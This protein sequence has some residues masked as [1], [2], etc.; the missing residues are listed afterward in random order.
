MA[1]V[2]GD[3]LWRSITHCL[4][5]GFALFAAVVGVAVIADIITAHVS[6]SARL[7]HHEPNLIPRY[8][9]LRV[10]FFRAFS[11]TRLFFLAEIA[12]FALNIAAC[13]VYVVGTYQRTV[14]GPVRVSNLVLGSIFAFD[15]LVGLIVAE[16]AVIHVCTLNILFQCLSVPSFF[17]ALGP[18]GF[19]N[20]TFLRALTAYITYRSVDR[21]IF[22][23]LTSS[24]SLLFRLFVKCMALVY[25]LAAGVQLLEIP[26]DILGSSFE[27]TWLP[28]GE[29]HFLTAVYFVVV[30]LSTVGYGDYTP[31]T[32]LGRAFVIL[33]IVIGVIIFS[34]SISQLVE[35]AQRNRGAGSFAKRANSRHVI[36]SGT[37]QLSDLVRFTSEFYASSRISNATAK[38]V[39]VVS[40]PSWTD[41]EWYHGLARNEYL[42]KRVVPLIGNIRSSTDLN[43]ARISS[44]DAI[45]F[46]AS[47]ANGSNSKALDMG[48]VIDILAVR[49]VRT[50]IPIYTTVLLNQSVIQM[51]VAQTLP[52]SP[53]DPNLL[54]RQDMPAIAQYHGLG[55]EIL[56][57]EL[58]SVPSS[59]RINYLRRAYTAGARDLKKFMNIPGLAVMTGGS[60][61]SQ[62]R[63]APQTGASA[64]QLGNER[65]D[66]AVSGD[67]ITGASIAT[68]EHD[69]ARSTSVCLQDI[70]AAVIAAHVSANGVGTL[71]SN[72]VL[73]FNVQSVV[74]DPAW[75]LE[76]HLGAVC[77]L[78]YLVIPQQLDGARIDDI[79]VL[80]YDH[81]LVLVATTHDVSESTSKIVLSTRDKVVKG[82]IGMFL[83]YHERRYAHPALMLAAFKYEAVDG[84]VGEGRA[85]DEEPAVDTEKFPDTLDCSHE[86]SNKDNCDAPLSEEIGSDDATKQ[87]SDRGGRRS[88]KFHAHTRK[89]LPCN[90]AVEA[91]EHTKRNSDTS[92]DN[93]LTEDDEPDT[94]HFFYDL[95]TF[96]HGSSSAN[97]EPHADVAFLDGLRQFAPQRRSDGY[98]PDNLKRHIIISAD[99]ESPLDNLPLLLQYLWRSHGRR[100]RRL[101]RRRRVPIIVIHPN[102][103]DGF[104]AP[105]KRYDGKCLFFIEDSS[106]SRDTWR[107][108]MLK[109]AKGVI[110]LADYGIP[111]QESDARTIFSI[112][113]L[114]TFIEN[115]QDV[116]VVSEL[117]E[118]KSLEFLRE[119]MHAR[120]IGVDFGEF[121]GICASDDR[122]DQT[123]SSHDSQRR[124]REASF[125]DNNMSRD[126]ANSGSCSV[127][128][129]DQ[130]DQARSKLKRAP[131]FLATSK[132]ERYGIIPPTDFASSPDEVLTRS[133]AGHSKRGT[134]FSRNRYASG[135]LLIH[136]SA[137]AL[138]VREYLEPGF[139][140][141]YTELLGA[142]KELGALKIRLVQ[143]PLRMFEAQSLVEVQDGLQ[144][145]R[146]RE[147][148]IRLMQLGATPLGL[149]RSGA[150]PVRIPT[151]RRIHR[152]SEIEAGTLRYLLE[153][154]D[155]F[156]AD[157]T[158]NRK[159]NGFLGGWW[160]DLI[161]V[162]PNVQREQQQSAA[163]RRDEGLDVDVDDDISDENE[164]S[165]AAGHEPP[166]QSAEPASEVLKQSN[167][168]EH[169]TPWTSARLEPKG[170]VP[171]NL[172]QSSMG[173]FRQMPPILRREN[174]AKLPIDTFKEY[175]LPN[176]KL[177]YVLT[178]PEPYTLVSEK[179][180]V[181]ILCHPEFELPST[182]SEGYK[183]AGRDDSYTT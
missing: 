165:G 34:N 49:N 157:D 53:K 95:D 52:A 86:E 68:G 182:W 107:R 171:A 123:G 16:S 20:F 35:N 152:G 42:R 2:S 80:L 71:I 150:A 173:K 124:L 137:L 66:S 72:M 27:N 76:Y 120:R 146:Y 143:V 5:G 63:S 44:A 112:M 159:V 140:H 108:A 132:M 46:I 19:L 106:A 128:N 162:L 84:F 93:Y 97:G 136:S 28:L 153:T 21:R 65:K 133:D 82:E 102:F 176:N 48:T 94:S 13:A 156:C 62:R 43:R 98:I 92:V 70:H 9:Q 79:A 121:A 131:S 69:L 118:E 147:V 148:F 158:E 110:I 1:P 149:Y 45:F 174:T 91:A 129:R 74:G 180:G 11:G 36:V 40:N 85:V 39:V 183:L 77:H 57:Q 61:P 135:D 73:D 30:S 138:L 178:M 99:G 75:L 130:D 10:R 115:D 100:S 105:F 175:Q 83:T 37:P 7:S 24:K 166:R 177:P 117:I 170:Y 17:L 88:R 144:C 15:L 141:F 96:A 89:G 154:T 56:A 29:W 78:T 87:K 8:F 22:A 155:S 32:M 139:V 145:I 127:S 167:A 90:D 60:E 111:W 168:V 6:R 161:N 169:S 67:D 103:P 54:F 31:V 164:I 160:S 142:G 41:T 12:R 109:T 33:M 47:P 113:T 58:Q 59:L 64:Q 114:D 26:G 116:F 101:R 14:K 3:A 55:H 172:S 104:R 125:A 134:L 4:E 25:I 163:W 126:W 179:D 81:G 23:Q 151:R 18:N 181:Y 119:P 38:V 50:D 122:P 51:Q